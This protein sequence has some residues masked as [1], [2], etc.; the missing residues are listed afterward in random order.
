MRDDGMTRKLATILAADIVG[1]SRLMNEDEE[2]TIKSWRAARRD[3]IDPNV[4]SYS[5]RIVKHTGDGFLA[6]FNSVT[7]AVRCALNMQTEL[8]ARNVGVPKNRRLD[9]RIGINVGDIVVEA[10]DIQGD[11]V[12]IAARLEGLADPGGICISGDVY[13]QVKNKFDLGYRPLGEKRVKNIAEPIVAYLIPA[14]G[15]GAPATP[16]NEDLAEEDL[17]S[18][19]VRS[20]IDASDQAPPQPR[21]SDRRR[22]TAILICLLTGWFGG[23]RFYLGLRKTAIVQLLTFGGAGLWTLA[24]LILLVTGE[25]EDGEGRRIPWFGRN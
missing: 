1:Y 24:D 20:L 3:V 6:E 10:D 11:G 13:R 17:E 16:Y 21:V 14:Q 22:L 8:S 25:L 19:A 15:D 9:F 7:N 2:G 23:H 18:E 4:A 12:N 5:G